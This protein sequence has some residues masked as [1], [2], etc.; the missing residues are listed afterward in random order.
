MKPICTPQNLCVT[1]QVNELERENV[2][3]K[4]K[5]RVTEIILADIAEQLL[6]NLSKNK[7]SDTANNDTHH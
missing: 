2:E 6:E 4:E 7:A 3:L 1:C 5:L